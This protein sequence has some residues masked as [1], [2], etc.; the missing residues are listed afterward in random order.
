M[1]KLLRRHGSALDLNFTP[2]RALA[3]GLVLAG[4]T[5][6]ALAQAPGSDDWAKLPEI[7]RTELGLYLTP[8]QALD[9]KQ[10]H[11]DK[12]L[13]LDIRTR[14]EAMFVGMASAADYL[15]PYTE[16]QE[17]MVDWDDKRSAYLQESNP[18]F[19]KGVADRLAAKGLTKTDAVIL[20]CRSG[21]R[22]ANAANLLKLSGYTRVYSI[23]EGFE[24]DLAKDGAKAGQR[25]VNGWKNAGLPW[26]YKLDKAKMWFPLH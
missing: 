13:F 25:A 26:S 17:I 3:L 23:A 2:L 7:K 19:A 21:D 14:A 18:D 12:V 22:S 10:A 16:L 1:E 11:P 4:L 8:K 24:G 9:M 5:P 6:L 20:I 15:V